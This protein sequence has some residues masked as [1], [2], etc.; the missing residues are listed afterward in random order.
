MSP[1]HEIA[2]T[3]VPSDVGSVLPGKSQAPEAFLSVNLEQKLQKSGFTTTI[4]SALSQPAKWKADTFSAGSVRS[5]KANVE[6][7]EQVEKA[8][9]T[10]LTSTDSPENPPFQLILG[11]EC[12]MLPAIM[13]ALWKH[14]QP[15]SQ[16]VGLIYIDADTDLT[17]PTDPSSNGN[18]ASMTMTH[19][20][21]LDGGLHSMKQF[22]RDGGGPVCDASNTVFFGLNISHP[23]N[24]RDHL[25][26]L[27]DNNYKV[28]SSSS[29]ATQPK[30]RAQEA[31][32]YLED[33]VDVI[34]V[35]LDVDSID[36]GTFPL[37]N[38]PNYTGVQFEVMME[39]LGVLLGGRKVGGLTVAEVNPDHD[40]GLEMTG[41][42]VERVVGMLKTRIRG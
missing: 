6:V 36:P 31:L 3:T 24:K 25:G 18:L 10:S 4:Q 39:A 37:A 16:R 34:M 40:L 41:R 22:S 27:F 35:H 26:F 20:M 21:Q 38:I 2:I 11:G 13:S 12:C 14:H 29:I 32:K 23:G 33:R 19:L 15:Q 5:E 1:S 17:K 30:V 42:L 7:C 9:L 28:V 8:I